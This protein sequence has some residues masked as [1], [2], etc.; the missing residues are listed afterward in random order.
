MQNGVIRTTSLAI[1]L[2]GFCFL[3]SCKSASS[4]S[5]TG[6]GTS[7]GSAVQMLCYTTPNA[8]VVRISAVFP[9]KTADPTTM[10]EEPWAKDFRT[11]IGQSGSEGGISV[12]CDQVT[13]K[14]AEK[15][16]A[17]ALRKQG[18]QVIETNWAYAGG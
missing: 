9:I 1:A 2:C 7:A 15:D 11:Y 17:D 3:T 18:H 8:Q 13:S 10:M 6:E 16:K 12:T 5:S 14:S 4:P